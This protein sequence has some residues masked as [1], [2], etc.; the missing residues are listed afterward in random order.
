M[1]LET[2][3]AALEQDVP[4][5]SGDFCDPNEDS[6]LLGLAVLTHSKETEGI[7]TNVG[8]SDTPL[9]SSAAPEESGEST[10]E[11][12]DFDA[13]VIGNK[14]FKYDAMFLDAHIQD[15][16]DYWDG[17]REPRGV[18]IEQS[19]RCF[20]CEYR[21]GCEWREQK[22]LEHTERLQREKEA[23]ASTVH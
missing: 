16:L 10:E 4:Q 23:L 8:V 20:T 22:A 9:T 2:T 17:R 19:G 7:I 21:E 5:V 6:E 18:T 1:T 12:N 15:V 13:S 11:E 3:S 14:D